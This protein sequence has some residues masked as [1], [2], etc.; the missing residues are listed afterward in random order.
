MKILQILVLILSFAVFVNAQNK[1]RS[2]GTVRDEYKAAITSAPIEGKSN[3]GKRFKVNTDSDGNFDLEIF[4]G[5]YKI[6]IKADGYKKTI[7]KINYGL[8]LVH[9]V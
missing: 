1:S 6:L 3:K 8:L 7:L 9:P 2:C 5:L 4:D